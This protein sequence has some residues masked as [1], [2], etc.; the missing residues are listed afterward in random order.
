ME[1]AQLA[2]YLPSYGDRVALFNFCKLNTN[3]SK[4][5]QGLLKKLREKLKLR[6]ENHRGDKEPETSH[7]ARGRPKQ[8]Y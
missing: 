5:K 2:Q 7:K 6:K 8:K 4:R 1:D 3:T